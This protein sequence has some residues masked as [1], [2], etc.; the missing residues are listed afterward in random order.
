MKRIMLITIVMFVVTPTFATTMCAA[1]DTTAVILDFN[2]SPTSYAYNETN[3]TWNVTLSYGK[4]YGMAACI[5]TN[6]TQ[7]ATN[8]SLTINGG[9]LNGGYCWCKITHPVSSLWACSGRGNGTL[10]NCVAS[11]AK[12]CGETFVNTINF[13]RGLFSSVTQ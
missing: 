1:E 9:E 3:K 11:C 7:G 6:G 2:V 13:R 4:I 8:S 12:L 10:N 5:T